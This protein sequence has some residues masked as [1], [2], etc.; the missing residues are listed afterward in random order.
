MGATT[1]TTPA[2]R[3]QDPPASPGRLRR[4]AAALAGP[5][6]IVAGVAFSLRGFAF[7]DRLSDAH[8]DILT[9]WLPRFSFLGR[10]IASGHVP[11]WNPFEMAGYRYAAD[12]QGGWLYLLPMTLFSQLSPAAAMRAF[13]VANPTIAGLGLFAFLRIE[14]LSRLAATTGGLSLAMLMSTSEI[15]ISMP[16][17]GAIA[18]TAIALVGAAGYRRAPRWPSRLAWLALGAFGWSQVA[19]AHLSHGLVVCTALLVAYLVAGLAWDAYDAR[20]AGDQVARPVLAASARAALFLVAMPPLSLAILLPRIDAL[21]A[22]SL[23][24]GYDQLEDA[25]G[26][27]GDS[28]TGSIQANGVWAAWPLAFGATPAPT[29]ARRSCSAFLSPGARA[30]IAAS[31]SRS[32]ERSSSPGS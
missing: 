5:A 2:R 7:A 21:E 30:V 23:A 3:A 1:V 11:L 12:P 28:D 25:I 27:L 31:P 9:F 10:S 14:R 20:A 8:P 22:S 15:A 16:F 26:V 19:T 17:A 32:E 6:L 18:W 29:P 24:A 13:I 4:I